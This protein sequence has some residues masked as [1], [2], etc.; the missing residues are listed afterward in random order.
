[1]LSVTLTG[2]AV[3]AGGSGGKSKY[4]IGTPT[5][6]LQLISFGQRVYVFVRF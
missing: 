4:P 1:M 6:L 3:G 5:I 2:V